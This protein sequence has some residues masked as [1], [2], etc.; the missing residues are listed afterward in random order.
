MSGG[1]QGKEDAGMTYALVLGMFF[2]AIVAF[3][4]LFNQPIINAMR[5]L[6]VA[7]LQIIDLFTDRIMVVSPNPGQP[8]RPA[9]VD[10]TLKWLKSGNASN[11]SVGQLGV[12]SQTI[13]AQYLRWPIAVI[14]ALLGAWALFKAPEN[15]FKKTYTMDK[16]IDVQAVTWRFITPIIKFNP[17]K[18]EQRAPGAPVPSVLPAF[19]EALSPEE[20]LAYHNVPMVNGAPD[21]DRM[22][23]AFVEQLGPRWQGPGKLPDYARALLTA[24][25]LRG[26]RKRDQ[27][28]QLLGDLSAQWDPKKGMVL[29]AKQK[30]MIRKTLADPKIGAPILKICSQH[31]FVVPALIHALLWCR[32]QGGVLAP[33]QFVWLR[34]VDRML[35]YPLN[36]VGRRAFH[37]E[38]SGAMAHYLAE[39]ALSRPLP[40]PK[41][42]GALTAVEVYVQETFPTVPP[43]DERGRPT[44]SKLMLA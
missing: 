16:L 30:S 20:W 1:N 22:R 3:W 10:E 6:R 14:L 23:R 19:A 5:W 43:R 39:I 24:F 34:A 29:T 25:A 21:R 8:P 26:A 12:I 33:G 31:G 18:S 11:L 15:N 27:S 36:N 4:Y 38:A 42:D 37:A 40:I 17:S 7:E 44:Q 41:V 28:D 35:W 9:R 13:V 2:I 32:Q